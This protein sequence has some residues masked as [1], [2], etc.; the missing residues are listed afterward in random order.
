MA[1]LRVERWR[2][3]GKD[4]LY[5]NTA[6]GDRVGWLDL[7]SG[8]VVLEQEELRAAFEQAVAAH[9][10]ADPG[11]DATSRQSAPPPPAAPSPASPRTT[12][13][14]VAPPPA[15]SSSA[16]PPGS[17]PPASS[18]PGGPFTVTGDWEDLSQRDAGA[19]AA[20]RAR[21]EREAAPVRTL[22]ARV[23]RVHTDERAWRIGAKGERLVA[24]RLQ[25][26]PDTWRTLH[27][28]PIGEN[29]A[30]I[31]HLVVGPGGVYTINAKHHPNKRVWV[32]GSTFMIIGQR[33]PYIR[34]ARHEA[35]RASRLLTAALGRTVEVTGIIAVVGAHEGFTVKEQP[36]D[37][38]VTTRKHVARWLRRRPVALDAAQVE[39]VCAAAR[40]SDTWR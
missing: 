8:D 38:H 24:A 18:R 16:S 9:R 28:I 22:A 21:Q 20:E 6:D 27:A 12:A 5:V 34:N 2:R 37:V 1:E 7:Q 33:V 29:G 30:D 19:A 25:K 23:L 14:P 11:Q 26:L 10:P 40:R 31:D 15:S 3:Y 36:A 39:E 32:G 17:P 4:R 13:P 35:R